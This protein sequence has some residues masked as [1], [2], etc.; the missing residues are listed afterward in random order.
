[1]WRRTEVGMD[2]ERVGLMVEELDE[3]PAAI[4]DPLE[5]RGYFDTRKRGKSAAGHDFPGELSE[6]ERVSLLEYLKTL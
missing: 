5:R 1:M 3:V 4:V 2:A 6:E